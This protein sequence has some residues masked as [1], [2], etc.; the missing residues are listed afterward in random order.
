MACWS[1]G[2]FQTFELPESVRAIGGI[3]ENASGIIWIGTADGQLL[4]TAGSKLV[5]ESAIRDDRE[6]SI[7]CLLATADG[8]VWMGFAGWGVGRLKAGQFALLTTAVGLRD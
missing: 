3:V 6:R 1:D 5:N 2:T 8:S 4:H 7:R